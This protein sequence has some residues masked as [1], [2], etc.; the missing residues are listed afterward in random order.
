MHVTWDR[1]ID[2]AYI[3]LAAPRRG[4]VTDTIELADMDHET[5][6]LNFVNLDVD[7][8][9]RLVGLEVLRAQSVLPAEVLASSTII[10]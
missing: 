8:N 5:P 6:T 10:G 7:K 4:L 1:S 9:G 2:A 3:S